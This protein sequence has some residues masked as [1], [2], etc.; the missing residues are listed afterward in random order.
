MT[1]MPGW[2]GEQHLGEA[3][4]FWMATAQVTWLLS[5]G[6]LSRAPNSHAVPGAPFVSERRCPRANQ[7]AQ[8]D[9]FEAEP[10]GRPS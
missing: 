4:G 2:G 1:G 5:E 3:P 6:Q 9:S 7:Q 10:E 8:D